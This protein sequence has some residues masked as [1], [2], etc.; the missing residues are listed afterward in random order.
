MGIFFAWLQCDDVAELKKMRDE[1]K[2][3]E[4]KKAIDEKIAE[5]ESKN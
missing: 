1:A 5:L 4:E 3:E 2:T